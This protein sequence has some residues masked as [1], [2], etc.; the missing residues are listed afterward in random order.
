VTG[1]FPAF[2]LGTFDV[3]NYGDLLFPLVAAHELG[4]HGIA[5]QAVS[6]TAQRVA[7]LSDAPQPIGLPDVLGGGIRGCGLLIGGGNIIHN[8]D[9]SGLREYVAQGVQKWAYVGLW[10]G[11]SLAG[12]VQDVPIIW[13]APGVPFPLGGKERRALVAS[14]LRAAS[15]V[16]VRDPGSA[17]FLEATGAGPVAVVPDTVLG[18]ARVWPRAGLLADHAALLARHGLAPESRTLAIH[19]RDRS[20]GGMPPAEAAALL[21]GFAARH[22]LVPLVVAIGRS[23]GDGRIARAICEG[24][25]GPHVRL[26][27]PASLRETAAAI[28]GSAAYAGA[29][30][31]GYVTASAYD[32]PGVMVTRPA[33]AKFGGLAAQLGRPGDVARDW[34]AGL[35]VLSDAL[36]APSGPRIPAAVQATIAAHWAETARL[37]QTGDPARRPAQL[38]FLADYLRFGLGVSGP[39][40]AFGAI[41][42]RRP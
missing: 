9:A 18:L 33:R 37:L 36:S 40:W 6:P 25:L 34:P 27:A 32:V 8:V 2:V 21:E 28:A 11:A 24:F 26:E 14:A 15:R 16:C 30:M 19:V 22:G 42:R 13:N 31:H 7:A 3:D 1:P 17:G 23:L 29:S 35:A 4:Q 39:D 38:A 20:L 41:V 10:L 12:A 5:V